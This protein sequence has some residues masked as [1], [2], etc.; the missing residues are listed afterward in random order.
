MWE[1]V[2]QWLYMDLELVHEFMR[3]PCMVR[4][5][6]STGREPHLPSTVSRRLLDYHQVPALARARSIKENPSEKFLYSYA[7]FFT[8][9]M[10]FPSEVN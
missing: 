1:D 4:N 8:I 9:L 5:V 6:A 7:E 3:Y 2:C 10:R